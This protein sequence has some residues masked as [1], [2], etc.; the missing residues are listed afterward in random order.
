MPIDLQSIKNLVRRGTQ[1]A[2]HPMFNARK[3]RET[4]AE[5]PTDYKSLPGFYL[6]HL[7]SVFKDPAK[8][9]MALTDITPLTVMGLAGAVPAIRALTRLMPHRKI[10]TITGGLGNILGGQLMQRTGLIGGTL[11]GLAGE[12]LGRIVGSPFD[13]SKVHNISSLAASMASPRT[14]TAQVL[15]DRVRAVLAPKVGFEIQGI[16]E[17]NPTTSDASI[18]SENPRLL[19]VPRQYGDHRTVANRGKYR[20]D[21]DTLI[22]AIVVGTDL[23]SFVGKG[24]AATPNASSFYGRMEGLHHDPLHPYDLGGPSSAGISGVP[25]KHIKDRVLPET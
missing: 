9:K 15:E 17:P 22:Q 24:H 18:G 6:K 25:G 11:G 20:P 23:N 4:F 12:A 3:L 14:Q 10:Q 1:V 16:R 13:R 19:D 8:L 21:I 7:R 5:P 2:L